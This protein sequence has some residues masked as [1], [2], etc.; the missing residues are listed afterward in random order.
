MNTVTSLMCDSCLLVM[1]LMW[2][3]LYITYKYNNEN[4]KHKI[5]A[6]QIHKKKP[7]H[8][9]RYNSQILYRNRIHDSHSV[10]H[11][12]DVYIVLPGC[13]IIKKLVIY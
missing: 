11:I 4:N 8:Y 1:R 10:S 2:S 5:K 6:C 12:N 7:I 3:R 13:K 9:L